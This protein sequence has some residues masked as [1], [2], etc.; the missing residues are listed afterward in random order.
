MIDI[1]LALLNMTDYYCWVC[2]WF[3][4]VWLNCLVTE[5]LYRKKQHRCARLSFASTCISSQNKKNYDNHFLPAGKWCEFFWFIYLTVT[6]ALFYLPQLKTAKMKSLCCTER[7]LPVF[8][9]HSLS[10]GL[11]VRHCMLTVSVFQNV[12]SDMHIYSIRLFSPL[13]M[14]SSNT[15]RFQELKFEVVQMISFDLNRSSCRYCAARMAFGFISL[16]SCLV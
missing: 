15:N 4:M 2:Q 1:L 9:Q 13:I 5:R 11:F 16:F 14:L 3:I 7:I 6:A 10:F 8:N 12:M